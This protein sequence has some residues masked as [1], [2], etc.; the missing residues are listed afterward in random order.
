MKIDGRRSFLVAQQMILGSSLSRLFLLC[1]FLILAFAAFSSLCISKA[2]DKVEIYGGYSYLRASI[3]V[4]QT[5][6][7]GPGSPCPPCAPLVSVAQ[8]ANLNGWELSGEYKFLPFLGAVADFNGNYGTLDGAGTRVHTF[9]FGP[10]VSLPTKFSP[11]AHALF[12]VAKESQ[13]QFSGGFN[14]LGA[15]KSWAVAIGGGMD[16]NVAR[17]LK[18]R[19]IQVDYVRTQLHGATQNQPRISAGVVFAF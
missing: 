6:P 17:F 19:L 14:S 5:T 2:Q 3:Q 7:L 9:L 11:F 13:D 10:Q 8:H 16:A 1:R 18:V 12:G 15:D 4:G